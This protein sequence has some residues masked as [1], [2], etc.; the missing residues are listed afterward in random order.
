M[1]KGYPD[2]QVSNYGRVKSQ[3]FGKERFLKQIDVNGYKQVGL[4]LNGDREAFYVHQLVIDT[5]KG[6]N[7]PALVVNHKDCDKANNN[8]ENLEYLTQRG[9]IQYG[10]EQGRYANNGKKR[11]SKDEL[12]GIMKMLSDGKT[13][14]RVTEQY[15]VTL[16]HVYVIK[17]K[18]NKAA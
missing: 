8:L 5:F 10:K 7:D 18:M 17:R 2:Y 6:T 4:C 11:L 12:N 16:V 14:R 1:I 15:E 13:A 9:N 3:K